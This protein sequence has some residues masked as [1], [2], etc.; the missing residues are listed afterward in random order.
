LKLLHFCRINTVIIYIIAYV[1]RYE[2][3]DNNI[4]FYF[5]VF[6]IIKLKIIKMKNYSGYY[7]R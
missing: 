7:E 2:I 3:G 1:R 4:K 6:N 5:V